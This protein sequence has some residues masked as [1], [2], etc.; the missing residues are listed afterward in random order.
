MSNELQSTG[1]QNQTP[2]QIK[3]FEEGLIG[4][5]IQHNLP[6]EKIFVS[7]PERLKVFSN[8][9]EILD[10]IPE[11]EKNNSI[12]LSKFTAGVASGLFDA[13]LNYLWDE[14]ILQIRKRVAQYDLE[15][16][17]DNAVQNGDKRKK[18][19]DE[20][21]LIKLDDYELIKGA[22]EIGLISELGFKHLEFINYMRNWASAA[23]PN[24]HELTGLQLVSWLET[25]VKEV[26]TLPISNVAIRIKELLGGIRKTTITDTEAA[27][28]G[29][30]FDNLTQEQINNLASG[31]FGIFINSSTEPQTRQNIVKLLPHIWNE[32]SEEVKHQFGI[33]YANFVANNYP[34]ERKLAKDFLKVVESESYIPEDLRVVEIEQTLESLLT[35][36]RGANNFYSEPTFMRQLRSMIGVPPKVPK[37]FQRRFILGMVEVFLTNA[38]GVAVNA[39]PFYKEMLRNLDENGSTI[40][41]FS[42]LSDEIASKLQFSLCSQKYRE[43]LGILKNNISSN[44][45]RELIEKIEKTTG[46]LDNLR[47]DTQLKRQ[48]RDLRIMK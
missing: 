19:K 40:A 8:I 31:F 18:L 44:Q 16:F 42:F 4:F 12:Y 30:F 47:I 46:R 17:Y 32:V 14:T 43:M 33:K 10:L 20:N 39:E 9:G 23:H 37:S 28:I 24:Q 15:Y 27:E 36:H 11:T 7:V 2:Q 3:Q 34:N 6:S 13:A 22:K 41:A 29:L 21:D 35:A 38:N 5:L 45:V 26:I 1:S 25:C 48:L